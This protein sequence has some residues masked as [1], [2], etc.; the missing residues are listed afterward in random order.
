[1]ALIARKPQ[2]FLPLLF[3]IADNLARPGH[4]IDPIGQRLKDRLQ[5]DCAVR[6]FPLRLVEGGEVARDRDNTIYLATHIEQR[7]STDRKKVFAPVGGE[8]TY[9]LTLYRLP[10]QRASH[11]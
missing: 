8:E 11:W 9:L 3:G 6:C 10:A 5:F 7:G 1:M 4:H 2:E